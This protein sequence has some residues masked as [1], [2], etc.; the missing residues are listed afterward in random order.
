MAGPLTG[1][2]VIEM[3]AIGPVPFAGMVLADLGAEVIRLDRREPSGLGIG[4]E[5][6]FDVPGRGKKSVALD[7]KCEEGREIVCK[8]ATAADID[9]DFRVN[10]PRFTIEIGK[11][12]GSTVTIA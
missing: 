7:L 5:P 9:L 10:I 6:R 3:A 1:V 8:L 4:T 12:T 2:T 11:S